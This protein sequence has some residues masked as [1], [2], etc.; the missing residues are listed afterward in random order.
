VH[1]LQASVMDS[2]IDYNDE[3]FYQSILIRVKIIVDCSIDS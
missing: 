1:L 2:K 3:F